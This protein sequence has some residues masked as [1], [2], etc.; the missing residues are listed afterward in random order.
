VAVVARDITELS[1]AEAALRRSAEDLLQANAALSR[2]NQD[3][4]RF[5]FI[6]SHDLQEPL[7]MIT[8]FSQLLVRD[9]GNHGGNA[10]YYVRTIC[11]GSARMRNLISDLLAFAEFREEAPGQHEDVDLNGIVRMVQLNLGRMIEDARATITSDTLPVISGHASRLVPLFQNLI[12]NAIKYRRGAPHIHVG[13]VPKD[14][15]WR[16]AVTD[17]G[18]GIDPAYHNQIFVPFKRLHGQE[19]QGSGIGLSI[20]Q[21]IVEGYGGRIWVESTPGSGSTFYFTLPAV[22]RVSAKA[23]N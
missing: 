10:E 15:F 19:V 23:A 9:Y 21:R 3:L 6:A 17:N 18:I 5:A 7:R 2:S 22:A 12:A 16:F 4:E 11:D 8:A 20:C 14:D 13:F 1:R